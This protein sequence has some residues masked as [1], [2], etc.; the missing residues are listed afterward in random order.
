MTSDRP[1]WLGVRAEACGFTRGLGFG[2]GVGTPN[3][4]RSCSSASRL[5]DGG[6]NLRLYLGHRPLDGWPGLTHRVGDSAID[7]G[8][9]FGH[10]SLDFRRNPQV[11]QGIDHECAVITLVL[12]FVFVLVFFGSALALGLGPRV[13][14]PPQRDRAAEGLEL[15]VR[16]AVAQ[17]DT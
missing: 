8:L 4:S 13:A 15:D 14:R 7:L 11:I 1:I 6:V 2:C 3:G 17:R 12:V 16:A 9:R 5:G 10:G